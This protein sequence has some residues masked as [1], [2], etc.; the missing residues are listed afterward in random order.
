MV[1]LIVDDCLFAQVPVESHLS[2]HLCDKFYVST[3][4][5]GMKSKII[6]FGLIELVKRVLAKSFDVDTWFRVSLENLWQYVFSFWRE[7]LGQWVVGSK[8]LLVEI[9]S[10]LI[11]KGQIAAHHRVEHYPD[12][13]N[14][15]GKTMVPI[16]CNHLNKFMIFCNLLQVQR[17]MDYH[18][19][20]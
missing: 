6:V 8:D 12:A 19:R 10:F 14:I 18:R 5:F 3:E 16:A 20:S 1:V 17:N 2:L 7:E 15:R 13:P 11:F 9:R 4:L